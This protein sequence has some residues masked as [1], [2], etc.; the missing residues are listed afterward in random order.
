MNRHEQL[1]QAGPR[2]RLQILPFQVIAVGEAIDHGFLQGL[3]ND[4][5]ALQDDPVGK[6]LVIK[7]D[8][9][10][11]V[12]ADLAEVSHDLAEVIVADMPVALVPVYR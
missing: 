1:I 9:D 3:V 12:I 11:A 2:Q 8:A 7:A 6:G 5:N 10:A 4:G